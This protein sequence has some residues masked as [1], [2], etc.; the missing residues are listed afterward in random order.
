MGS[1]IKA[2][3]KHKKREEENTASYV[4]QSKIFKNNPGLNSWVWN[5]N[6]ELFSA[7]VSSKAI[8]AL[9]SGTAHKRLRGQ[10]GLW[11]TL[12]KKQQSSSAVPIM[13]PGRNPPVHPHRGTRHR[14]QPSVR[15]ALTRRWH[16]GDFPT[17]QHKGPTSQLHLH[18]DT[19]H[20]SRDL[21]TPMSVA[22]LSTPKHEQAAYWAG[23]T[24]I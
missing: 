10:A 21:L 13:Q 4:S 9:R 3:L 23:H 24:Q 7:L 2:N 16:G 17:Q 14:H 8:S 18:T 20:G 6:T 5:A 11:D 15:P 12:P 1:K 22:Q 19:S